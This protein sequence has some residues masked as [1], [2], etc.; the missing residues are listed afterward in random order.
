MSVSVWILGDQL[1][2]HHPGLAAGRSVVLI[3]SLERLRRRPY[4][5][6]KL[7]LIIAALRHYAAGL[8]D[9]GYDVD[10]RR[11][12]DFVSGLREH[13]MASGNTRLVCMAA[14][15]YDTRTLQH[16]L[17]ERLGVE[18][19]VLPNTQFLVEQL[20]PQRA[21][22]LMEPFYREMRRRTG[23]LLQPDGEPAGGRWNFDAE[24]R[25]RYD[26]RPLP[27][28]PA[29]P[30]DDLTQRALADIE[31]DCPAALG[32]TAGFDLAVTRE[33]ALAALDDFVAHRLADF[34]PFEDAM[35]SSDAVLFHSQL[36]AL[37]NIGLLEPR[38]ACEAAVRA[39]E[40]GVAPLASVEGF[41]RQIIGWR[42]YIYYRY[43]ELMPDLRSANAWQHQ[44]S[45]PAWY[46]SGATKMRCLQHAISR[47]LRD[48]YSHHIERL[49]LLCNF[50][51]LAG[52]SPQAV[53]DWFLECYVD[54]YDWVVTPNVIGMGLN[55]DGGRVATK[56]YIASANYIN[57]MSDYCKGCAYNH[58]A[59][60]G[61]GACPFNVLYW[62]FLLTHEERLR[63]NPRAGRAVLALRHLD[64]TERAQVQ[65]QAQDILAELAV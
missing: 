37:L 27:P 58:R 15:E 64:D 43:W 22:K 23:L 26:G 16:K 3:E 65:A 28:R 12:P 59:R 61:P 35:S 41:V 7:G 39:Y 6:R 11:A 8:R 25:K 63:A 51:V 38:E 21:P 49:M 36:S 44:R 18:V 48:G 60:S 20:P 2:S 34:G 10:L 30:P 47:V 54:A 31:A 29:F 50:A 57:K 5:K 55:A 33:Q 45:L 56:P 14:A 9:Q 13:L 52:I 53:N 32:S 24:N 17:A 46:W 62:N 4:H 1:L 40:A 19:E 42:E